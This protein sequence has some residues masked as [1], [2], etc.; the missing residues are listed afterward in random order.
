MGFLDKLLS[1]RAVDSK[2]KSSNSF[3][4]DPDR[5]I[6]DMDDNEKE[7]MIDML[8]KDEFSEGIDL[9]KND[10]L[11]LEAAR[12]V[13]FHQQGSTSLIQRKL[14]IGYNRA[15][16]IIDQLEEFGIVSP[17]NGISSREVYFNKSSELEDY[18]EKHPFLMSKKELFYKKYKE[19][20]ELRRAEYV[21]NQQIENNR[22]EKEEIKKTID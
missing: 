11:I 4:E 7:R 13:V 16:R 10:P 21:K 12:L 15:G 6:L 1:R 5:L 2:N 3:M 19:V 22:F 17:F 20:I 18:L 8:A 14:A 9:L